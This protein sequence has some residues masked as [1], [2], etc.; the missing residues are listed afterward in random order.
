MATAVSPFHHTHILI[1]TLI[2]KQNSRPVN[3]IF[4][5][6]NYWNLSIEVVNPILT[7]FKYKTEKIFDTIMTTVHSVFFLVAMHSTVS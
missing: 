4:S 5:Q 1:R 7:Y 2:N 3:Y 6:A